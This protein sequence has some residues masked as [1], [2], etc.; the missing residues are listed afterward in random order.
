MSNC[1]WFLAASASRSS[2]SRCH[3]SRSSSSMALMVLLQSLED[4]FFYAW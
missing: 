4:F 1:G 2:L 3:S